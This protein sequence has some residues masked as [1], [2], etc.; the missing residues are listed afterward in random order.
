M[1]SVRLDEQR[2]AEPHLLVLEVGVVVAQPPPIV[3]HGHHH[4][5]NKG[6][7]ED[8]PIDFVRGCEIDGWQADLQHCDHRTGRHDDE[9]GP[10][11]SAA[12]L[13]HGQQC[14]DEDGGQRHAIDSDEQ[15]VNQRGAM[16]MMPNNAAVQ[17]RSRAGGVMSGA[18]AL[19]RHSRR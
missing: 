16:A 9:N 2:K 7:D 1:S 12:V 11:W 4:I 10:Q 13:Q 17:R 6:H 19:P 14:A 3:S 5:Y 8:Q 15:S 18:I